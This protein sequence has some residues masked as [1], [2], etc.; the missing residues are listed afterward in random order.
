MDRGG[1]LGRLSAG[2]TPLFLGR[3]PIRNEGSAM[4]IVGK[5]KSDSID[6]F[7]ES[8]WSC[9]SY[10]YGWSIFIVTKVCF[11][12]LHGTASRYSPVDFRPI[13]KF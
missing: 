6:L 13:A 5:E 10:I 2:H 8:R 4:C 11:P 12:G 7:R 9:G 1:V 3:Q